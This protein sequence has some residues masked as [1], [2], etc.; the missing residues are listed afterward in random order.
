M[1]F[2]SLCIYLNFLKSVISE[3]GCIFS[4]LDSRIHD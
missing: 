1:A 4:K 2:E 3:D